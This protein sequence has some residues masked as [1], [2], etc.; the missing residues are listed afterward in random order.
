MALAGI[1]AGGT[2]SRMGG[3]MPKQFLD[4]CGEPVIIH[5]IKRFLTHKDISDI[6]VGINPDWYDYAYSLIGKYF[7]ER[8]YLT[9]GG[10]DRNGTIV[11]I[12]MYAKEKLGV[13]DNE[14]L[15]THDAVRPFASSKMIDDSIEAMKYCDI[16][17]AAIPSTDTMLISDDGITAAEFPLRQKM[18]RVQTPQT[19]RLGSFIEMLETVTEEERVGITDAC[20]LFHMNGKTVRLIEGAE[21]NIK[22][23]YPND[24]ITAKQFIMHNA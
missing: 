1:V 18:F 14:I 12:I 10:A 5:T 4:L 21:T 20:K 17:T 13:G 24:F 19:F 9:K 2:G 6:I 22:L 7:D 23:T 8:V 15:I 16:C 11:N 3:D